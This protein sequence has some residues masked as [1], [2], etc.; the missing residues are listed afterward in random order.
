MREIDEAEREHLLTQAVAKAA[1]GDR[2]SLL[3]LSLAKSE[4]LPLPPRDRETWVQTFTGR[5]V[6]P[7][8]PRVEDICA[9]DIA[10]ALANQCRYTG[11]TRQFY[12]VAQHSVL[13]AQ[14]CPEAPL[15]ALL[16]DAAEAYLADVARPV[17]RHLTNY[18][19]IE[20]RLERVIAERF[21]LPW[22]MPACVKEIDLRLL[23]TERRDLMATPPIP[24]VSTENVEPLSLRIEPWSAFFAE[25]L[26][27]K[28]LGRLHPPAWDG[29]EADYC[30]LG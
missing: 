22:P 23:A 26:F 24:W 18:R 27:L 7:L 12:S 28:E 17:K 3:L 8:N 19:Q 30:P 14:H 16:H 29:T 2:A 11:H 25:Q 21:G 15:W 10:H 5:Q 6:W 1:A 20:E 4:Q 9:E 13:A